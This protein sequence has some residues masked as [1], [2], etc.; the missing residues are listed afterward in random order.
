MNTQIRMGVAGLIVLIA[1]ALGFT[2]FRAHGG[3]SS[4]LNLGPKDDGRTVQVQASDT[5]VITLDSNATT[6]F[7]WAL[8]GKP[9]PAVVELVGSDYIAPTST[10]VGAGGQEVWRFRATGTGTTSLE[11]RYGRS[12]SGE[13]AGTPFRITV[14]VTAG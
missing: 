13:T 11:L 3:A 4:T 6:G 1:V 9:D 7:R 5:I 14:E 2:Q 8:T 12:F 10:L